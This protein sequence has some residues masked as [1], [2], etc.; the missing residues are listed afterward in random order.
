MGSSSDGGVIRLPRDEVDNLTV[1]FD[2][3]APRRSSPFPRPTKLGRYIVLDVLGI[4][5]MGYVCTAY[6]P[7]LDRK[8][9]IKLL[10]ERYRDDRRST[11]GQARLV[12]EAQAL[13][14]LTHPNIVTVHDVD[15][16][17]G[18]IYM[19]MEYVDGESI[20]QWLKKP[21]PWRE[22]VDVFI[23][24]ARGLAAAHGAGI[25]HRDFKPSNVLLGRDGRVLVVDFGLAK[26]ERGPDSVA[27]VPLGDARGVMEVIGST[28]DAKL[29]QAGRTV[30]TPAYMAPEQ[31]LGLG[32]D[33]KTDQFSFGVSL[34]EA[35][36]GDLPFPDTSGDE[37]VEMAGSG[38]VLEP[39]ETVVPSWVFKVVQRTLQPHPEDRYPS[40]HE[41]IAALQADPARRRRRLLMGG[42]GGVLVGLVGALLF[43]GRAAEPEDQVCRGAETHMR[44]VWSPDQAERVREAFAATGKPFAGFAWDAV[45]RGL[46]DYGHRW[47]ELH[48]QV[49]EAT[50]VRREQSAALMDVRMSCLERGRQEVRALVDLFAEADDEVVEKAADAVQDLWDIERCAS[51]Q[52]D[53]TAVTD[54]VMAAGVQELDGFQARIRALD[55]TGKLD[56][57]LETAELALQRAKEVGHEPSLAWAQYNAARLRYS[58][59]PD[60]AAVRDDLVEAIALAGRTQQPELEARAWAKLMALESGPL[61][62]PDVALTLRLPAQLAA[63]RSNDDLAQAELHRTTGMVLARSGDLEGG[64]EEMQK[65]REAFESHYG[66]RYHGVA[67]LWINIGAVH[68]QLERNEDALRAFDQAIAIVRQNAGPDHPW[69][70]AALLNRGSALKAEQDYERAYQS[71]EQALRIYQGIFPADDRRVLRTRTGMAQALRNLGRLEEARA[72]LE[73]II[74]LLEHDPR[75][76]ANAHLSLAEVFEDLAREASAAGRDGGPQWSLA[77]EHYLRTIELSA[78]TSSARFVPVGQQRLCALQLARGRADAGLPYCEA[79]WSAR[80]AADS[81]DGFDAE[82]IVEL[83]VAIF[84]QRGEPERAIERLRERIDELVAAAHDDRSAGLRLRLADLLWERGQPDEARAEASRARRLWLDAG[85]DARLAEADRWLHS[86]RLGE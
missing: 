70:A 64:L 85:R 2:D 43:M 74:P 82:Q 79:A 5:G 37:L 25:T 30:G 63:D 59:A 12:R 45:S 53:A 1:G 40:M 56:R 65:A 50:N 15:T 14:K 27:P 42:T 52:E 55:R 41:V 54:P 44:G 71:Y 32:A 66:P 62:H 28:Q 58:R 47:V 9:A 13:A 61:D 48:T 78:K 21:R 29:T 57:A 68:G 17:D 8:V 34:Y 18:Q 84:R 46:D 16:H 73:A 72:E 80:D 7:K 67:V 49:C 6:D 60:K 38:R 4:G 35:L 39:P 10:R 83:L 24:A 23:A 75:D 76:L 22:I 36:Y 81:T 77:E 51:V 26:S 20:E 3:E 31:F 69:L 11:T 86:H 19:A 33:I